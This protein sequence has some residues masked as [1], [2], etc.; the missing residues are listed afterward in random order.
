MTTPCFRCFQFQK[1]LRLEEDE[2][3]HRAK[4]HKL[5]KVLGKGRGIQSYVDSGD[6]VTSVMSNA[7]GRGCEV[8]R[9][10]WKCITLEMWKRRGLARGHGG[11]EIVEDMDKLRTRP[12]PPHIRKLPTLPPDENS[13]CDYFR[14]WLP[15][16]TCFPVRMQ[17]S[18]AGR[19]RGTG[20]KEMLQGI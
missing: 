16:L 12:V 5:V 13:L 3:N 6:G 17:I 9:C 7:G 1:V 14:M 19:Y 2:E 4:P 20:I 8:T 10:T 15:S 11:L 18:W